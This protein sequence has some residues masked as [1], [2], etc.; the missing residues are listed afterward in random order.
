MKR[1][2]INM[3][4]SIYN[5]KSI[6][7]L[8]T[9]VTLSIILSVSPVFSS[10]YFQDK[11]PLKT[12]LSLTCTQ[13]ANHQIMVQAKI[14]TKV[15][16]QYVALP[17]AEIT[18]YNLTDSTEILLGKGVSDEK[19]FVEIMV[20]AMDKLSI[21]EDGY[22]SI[23]GSFDGDENH[24]ASDNDFQFKPAILEL[25]TTE[26]DS[27]NLITIKIFEDS[28][29]ASPLGDVEIA[30]QVSRMFS[31]LTIATEYTDEDGIVE[32][33]FPND[34]PGGENGEL[35]IFVKAEDTD[36]YASLENQLTKNWG[37]PTSTINHQEARALWRPNAPLWMVFTFA[38]LMMLVWGHFLIIIYKLSLI[39][40]EGK[41]MVN[42]TT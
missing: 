25:N 29:N 10:E 42:E 8:F 3:L 11:K 9:L 15:D 36:D 27:V 23:M 37:T 18:I 12:R 5:G 2:L 7:R 16:K 30:L 19:G 33:E 14:R 31:N 6:F 13:L 32:F 21:N 1:L 20:N 38:F 39:R 17:N 40:K 41:S 28:E 24:K 22:F 26:S 4:T 34:L 35:F